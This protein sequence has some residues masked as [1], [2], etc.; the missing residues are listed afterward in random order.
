MPFAGPFVQGP[1]GQRFAYL[2]IG[3]Y[4]GQSDTQWS[5]QLKIPLEGITAKMAACG[6]VY[7]TRVPG[8]A[9][10]GGPNCASVKDFKG[11]NPT[12]R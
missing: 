2:D 8:T 5:R 12:K 9:R 7:E 4:A 3:T 11:W 1:P 10:D 6:G